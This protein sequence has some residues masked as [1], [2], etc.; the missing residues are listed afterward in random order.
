MLLLAGTEP[1]KY[2]WKRTEFLSDILNIKVGD[3]KFI[4]NIYLLDK[5][6]IIFF[7]YNVHV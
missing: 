7:T 4:E 3:F 1:L 2:G 6:F 5:F